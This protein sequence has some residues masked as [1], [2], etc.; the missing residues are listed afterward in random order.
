MAVT[1]NVNIDAP[2]DKVWSV[3]ADLGS[4]YKWNP[5]VA[6]SH[7]TSELTQGEGA[8]RHCDLD[9]KNYLEERAFDWR[10]GESF[11]IDVFESSMPLESNIVSFQIA[12]AGDAT[13]VSVTADYKLKFGPIG[14]LMDVLFGKRMLQRGFDDMMA[15]L[16]HHIETGEL[17]GDSVPEAVASTS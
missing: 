12:P 4:I 7:T 9:D 5:G 8:T 13:R 14:A 16:K 1:S 6:K 10:E 3:L 2:P 17:I 15:G 11:K